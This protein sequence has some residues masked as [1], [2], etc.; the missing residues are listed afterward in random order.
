LFPAKPVEDHPLY[1]GIHI[2]LAYVRSEAHQLFPKKESPDNILSYGK[3][4]TI[5]EDFKV[6]RVDMVLAMEESAL[7]DSSAITR[8]TSQLRRQLKIDAELTMKQT[9]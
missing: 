3:L 7:N 4:R 5:D 8:L 9:S 1:D 2:P 6:V